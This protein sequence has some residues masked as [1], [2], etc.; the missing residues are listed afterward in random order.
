MDSK[1]YVIAL[2]P[3]IWVPVLLIFLLISAGHLSSIQ[4]IMWQRLA[5]CGKNI[6]LAMA[7]IRQ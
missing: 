3:I 2:N 4:N 7:D 6:I 1:L 5:G